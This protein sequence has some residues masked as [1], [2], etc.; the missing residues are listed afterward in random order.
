MA[1]LVTGLLNVPG[2]KTLRLALL[3]QVFEQEC[4]SIGKVMSE[5]VVIDTAEVRFIRF[6]VD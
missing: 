5:L 6:G 2:R 1:D 4:S 3:S